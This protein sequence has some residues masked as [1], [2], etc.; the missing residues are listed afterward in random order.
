M[1]WLRFRTRRLV[2]MMA[3]LFCLAVVLLIARWQAVGS[4]SRAFF[5][6]ITLLVTLWSLVL[7]GLRRR[8]PVLPLGRMSRWTQFHVYAG[9]FALPVYAMHVPALWGSGVWD[10]ALSGLFWFA[11]ISGLYGIYVSRALP[12]RLSQV[13]REERF[14]RLSWHRQQIAETASE[15]VAGYQPLAAGP[16][17]QFYHRKLSPYFNSRPSL[18]FV[19]VPNATRGRRLLDGLQAFDA[20]QA[21]TVTAVTEHLAAL[22]R[23]RDDLDYQFAIQLRLRLWLVLHGLLSLA[24]IAAASAHGLMHWYR[25]G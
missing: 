11:A 13:E 16:L 12:K 6:G 21:G 25:P 1:D 23:R 15:L 7:M 14:E 8:I 2:G 19:M 20:G 4:S 17:V 9:L 10:G 18:A 5:T 3:T 24:L 22:I